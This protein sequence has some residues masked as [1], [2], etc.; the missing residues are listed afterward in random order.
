MHLMW[1]LFDYVSISEKPYKE[2]MNRALRI[3]E[4]EHGTQQQSIHTAEGANAD[5]VTGIAAPQDEQLGS[6]D[7]TLDVG[8]P[9][10]QQNLGVSFADDWS[11]FGASWSTYWPSQGPADVW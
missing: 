4:Q 8:V 6:A 11:L 2:R 3:S 7:S 10:I 1:T 5:T 9:N